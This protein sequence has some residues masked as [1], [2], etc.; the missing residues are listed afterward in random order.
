MALM[1][2][3]TVVVLL[4]AV[5]VAGLLRS[6]ADILRALHSLGAGVGDPALDGRESEAAGAS[7]TPVTMGPTLPPERSSSS[8]PT[9]VG[10]TPAGEALAVPVGSSGSLTLLAFLTSGCS[11]CAAFWNAF[12]TGGETVLPPG[13]SLLVV[14]KGSQFELPSEVASRAGRT[15]VVMSDEAW[16]DYEVPGSPFFALVD[17][18][19]GRRIG[20]GVA[21]H[22]P[23]LLDLL[24]RATSEHRSSVTGPDLRGDVR[25]NGPERER[26]NDE[27]LLAAGIL[28]G[29]PSLYPRSVEDLYGPNGR[30]GGAG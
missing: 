22:L 9:V 4:L 24:R 1:V 8:A 23:Q 19:S 13:V 7:P 25:A 18:S 16:T 2:A 29:D 17:G 27:E 30:P 21:N 20:E 5:L 6:H 15:P 28:P 12:R 3:L 10:L 14:T 26:S 11:T